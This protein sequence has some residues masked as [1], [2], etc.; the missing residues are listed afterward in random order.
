MRL[1][2]KVQIVLLTCYRYRYWQYPVIF[3]IRRLE[4]TTT[5]RPKHFFFRKICNEGIGKEVISIS[6]FWI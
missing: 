1:T 3:S 4:E 2:K 6:Q 5:S